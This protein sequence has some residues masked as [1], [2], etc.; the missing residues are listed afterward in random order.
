[1][2]AGGIIKNT[3]RQNHVRVSLRETVAC[4]WDVQFVKAGFLSGPVLNSY[5]LDQAE[6]SL[7][8]KQHCESDGAS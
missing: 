7:L 4:N 5:S 6:R 3:L 8:A 2:L 1:V